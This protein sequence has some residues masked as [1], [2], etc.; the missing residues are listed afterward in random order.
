MTLAIPHNVVLALAGVYGLL[1]AAT[2]IVA[3]MERGRGRDAK[4][5]SELSLR[6]RSWWWMV[7]AFTLAVA[8]NETAA[9]VFLGFISYLAL[10]EYF[11]LIPTR[12]IDRSV[13]LCAYLAVPAQFYWI[14]DGWYGMFIVFIPIWV[15]L[16]FPMLMALRGETAG[17]LAAVGTLSWGLMM[18]V[19]ALSHLGILLTTGGPVNPVAG[20]AGLLFFVVF[21][22]QFNDV[23]Q[24]TWGKL[25]S[26]ATGGHRITPTVS[27]NKTWEG[28]LGGL[29]T[30]AA[31]GAALSPWLT[32][33]TPAWGALAGAIIAI[34]GFVGDVTMSAM[35][36]DLGVKDTGQLIP[37]HGGIL[38]RVDSLTYTAPV[39]FHFFRYVFYP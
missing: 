1:V 31:L 19:F 37:G 16:F 6:I 9:I 33:M 12:R 11:S 13:I 28:F 10:K 2:L 14:A 5:P 18:T 35:K 22:T 15:F 32:P 36:R 21:L 7:A 4:G 34:A 8:F 23:A 38:D 30:A 29:A 25:L 20:G 39:F 27:P 24:F 17:H 3:W 26:R